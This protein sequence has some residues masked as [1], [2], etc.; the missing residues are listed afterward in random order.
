MSEDEALREAFE[1]GQDIHASAASRIFGIPVEAVNR[2]QRSKGKEDNYGNPNGMSAW[3]LSQRLRIPTGEANELIE[4]YQKSYPKVSRYLA[5]QVESAR[6]KGYVET[7]LGRRRYVPEIRSRNRTVRSFA[8]RVA[9]N[10][11]I[12]GSQAT[13]SAHNI[14]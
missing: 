5:E 2:E 4:Q 9:V 11:P 8:E 7:M 13:R 12:Q 10:M 1:T 14:T 3:G 6:E